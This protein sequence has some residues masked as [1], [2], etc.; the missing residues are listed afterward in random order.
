MLKLCVCFSFSGY[1]H[2]QCTVTSTVPMKVEVEYVITCKSCYQ[3]EAT[4]GGEKY[5]LALTNPLVSQG[6]KA[7]TAVKGEKQNGCNQHLVSNGGLRR[8]AERIAR[9]ALS[10][11][12]Q[13]V[14]HEV[15]S[16][17]TSKPKIKSKS[18]SLGLIWKKKDQIVDGTEFRLKNVLLKGNSTLSE[19]ECDLCRNPYNSNFTYIFCETCTSKHL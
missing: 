7:P 9:H 11:E 17:S 16:A 10:C 15:R 3:V 2:F 8:S 4:M 6:P 19:V 12:P 18:C 14:E 1:C 5:N 13:N